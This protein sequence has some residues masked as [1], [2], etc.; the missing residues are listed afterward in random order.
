MKS[1]TFCHFLFCSPISRE[2]ECIWWHEVPHIDVER[3]RLVDLKT[4]RP[5][6]VGYIHETDT[7]KLIVV[8]SRPVEHNTGSWQGGDISLWIC[9]T[10]QQVIITNKTLSFILLSFMI[11]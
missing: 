2:I 7:E 6:A 11:Q 3:F 9:C 10:L 1:R 5:G 4:S 8:I